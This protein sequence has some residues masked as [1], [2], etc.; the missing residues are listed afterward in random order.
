HPVF[1]LLLRVLCVSVVPT[2]LGGVFQS[3]FV[4][5]PFA[6]GRDVPGIGPKTKIDAPP[7]VRNAGLVQF[8]D[9]L[10]KV[11]LAGAERIVGAGIVL[12]KRAVRIDQVHVCYLTFEF[13]E[14]LQGAAG[15]CLLCA[16]LVGGHGGTHV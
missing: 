9:Q 7:V 1:V 16:V 11:Q 2:A 10:L 4:E 14:Q 13:V 3:Q 8:G 6:V 12:V 15:Q 5:V